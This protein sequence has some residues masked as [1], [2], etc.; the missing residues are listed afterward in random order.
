MKTSRFFISAL[1]TLALQ[2][3]LLFADDVPSDR[4]NFIRDIDLSGADGSRVFKASQGFILL[5]VV[6]ESAEPADSLQV[7]TSPDGIDWTDFKPLKIESQNFAD[8]SYFITAGYET[9]E[10]K[11]HLYY[12]FRN[13][14]KMNYEY[15]RVFFDTLDT[16]DDRLYADEYNFYDGKR[17]SLEGQI[18]KRGSQGTLVSDLQSALRDIGAFGSNKVDGKYG[19]KTE[20][21]VRLFQ[22]NNGLNP[23]GI[24]GPKTENMINQKL[25]SNK[26]PQ[27]PIPP[28][29]PNE[30]CRYTLEIKTGDEEF[31]GTDAQ[32]DIELF[33][34][35][36]RSLA[37]RNLDNPGVNDFERGQIDKFIKTGI[38]LNDIHKI[39]LYNRGGG[40]GADWQVSY[41][42]VEG[43][44]STVAYPIG[45]SF[46]T[47]IPENQSATAYSN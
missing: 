2:H 10:K 39:T 11:Q 9:P 15:L 36:G 24:A 16:T 21:A 26:P 17:L 12:R 4:E 7:S 14:F 29:P 23:D 27:P 38:C 28:G 42:I 41:V 19:P 30:Q 31:A 32:I 35:D 34:K 5:K 43:Y 46:D 25:N 18:L 44:K 40:A 37:F 20:E 33:N 3:G 6:W 22:S 47:L 45:V 1:L 8:G 13:E